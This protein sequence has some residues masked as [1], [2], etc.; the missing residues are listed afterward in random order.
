MKPRFN[1]YFAAVVALVLILVSVS[2]HAT[3]RRDP[4]MIQDA[5]QTQAA[6]SSSLVHATLDTAKPEQNTA[7]K[8]KAASSPK[9]SRKKASSEAGS[10][11]GSK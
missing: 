10:S 9:K 2:S 7:G 6:K 4:P 1:F 8:Q 3:E 11:K 5:P